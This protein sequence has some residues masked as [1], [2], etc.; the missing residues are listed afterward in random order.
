MSSKGE[1]PHVEIDLSGGEGPTTKMVGTFELRGPDP[2]PAVEIATLD[3]KVYGAK[4]VC[5][6]TGER[7]ALIPVPRCDQCRWWEDDYCP[8]WGDGATAGICLRQDESGKGIQASDPY[9]GI[10]TRPDFGCVQWE[11]REP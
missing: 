3:W 10:E 11:K 8:D 5:Q 9:H 2:T 7:Q 4:L 1:H 6:K